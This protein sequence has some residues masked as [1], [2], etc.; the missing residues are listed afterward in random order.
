[1]DEAAVLAEASEAYQGDDPW[2]AK[3]ASW[4]EDRAK[5]EVADVLSDALDRPLSQQSKQD[6]QRVAVVLRDLGYDRTRP[7]V[8]GRRLTVWRRK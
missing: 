2:R 5:V 7:L 3:I 1:M 6:E 4:C 8:K